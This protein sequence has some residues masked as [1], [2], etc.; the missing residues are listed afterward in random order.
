MVIVQAG[1]GG[2]ATL[3]YQSLH[4]IWTVVEDNTIMPALDKTTDDVAP[5]LP[6]PTMAICIVV[7]SLMFRRTFRSRFF[8]PERCV[9]WY[10]LP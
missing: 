4:P 6:N 8:V 10:V 5:I 2:V 3:L 7:T 9:V 1:T